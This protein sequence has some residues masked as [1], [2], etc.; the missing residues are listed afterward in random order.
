MAADHAPGESLR[1]CVNDSDR[2]LRFVLSLSLAYCLH[3]AKA[4]R[5]KKEAL[6]DSRGRHLGP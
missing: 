5:V 2:S 1:V 4:E 3:R 6:D